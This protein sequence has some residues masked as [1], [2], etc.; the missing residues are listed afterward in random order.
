MTLTEVL[1]CLL[2]GHQPITRTSTLNILARLRKSGYIQVIGNKG[3]RTHR[4]T[5][6]GRAY[7]QCKTTEAFLEAHN[8]FLRSHDISGIPEHL[9]SRLGEINGVVN[10]DSPSE[11]LKTTQEFMESMR[12]AKSIWGVSG[13]IVPGYTEAI[14]EA[15]MN[16]AAVSLILSQEV[17]AALPKV[18]CPP[19]LHLYVIDKAPI[20]LCV[21]P[22]GMR[23]GLPSGNRYDV[24]SDLVCDQ[25][26]FDWGIELFEYY[27]NHAKEI[28]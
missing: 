19:T 18:E 22:N 25:S 2:A 7:A 14:A 8:G 1:S 5:D 15:L 10:H 21:L 6:L 26:A 13:H 23:L 9:L 20:G 27:R 4:L 24:S 28:K 3:D 16:G 11:P 17:F 12:N